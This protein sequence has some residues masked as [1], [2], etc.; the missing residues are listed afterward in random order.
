MPKETMD[1]NSLPNDLQTSIASY[2][3]TASLCFFASTS[4]R[5]LRNTRLLLVERQKNLLSSPA[6]NIMASGNRT[7]LY[8]QNAMYVCGDN[9]YGQL[10]LGHDNPNRAYFTRLDN[11]S[12]EIL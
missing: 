8:T 6:F 4:K 3:D 10:G 5:S 7:M 1:F 12:G 2:L 9:S 11:L